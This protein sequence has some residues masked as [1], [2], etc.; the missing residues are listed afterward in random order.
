MPTD[1]QLEANRLNARSSTGPR[2]IIGKARVSSNALKH[3]LTGRDIVFPSENRNDYDAFRAGLIV[4]LDP[5]GDLE[6]LLAD[7]LVADAWRIRR[8]PILEAAL[9]RRGRHD[10]AVDHAQAI[11]RQ[12][13]SEE[14]SAMFSAMTGR[15][16]QPSPARVA[17]ERKL[18][19]ARI[20]NHNLLKR[21]PL[22]DATRV[23]ETSVDAFSNL[24]RH[25]RALTRSMYS[26]LHELQR[27]QAVRAG[28]HVPA[29]AV[30]DVNLD[31]TP[32]HAPNLQ[33]NLEGAL[34]SDLERDLQGDPARDLEGD[35]QGG[36]EGDLE[37]PRQGD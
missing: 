2:T 36:L 1:R 4:S 26:T 22:L 28:E 23:L 24:W 8:I 31:V 6:G 7:K 10:L 25:E 16:S 14:T 13:L 19:H 12:S 3:G 15:F 9:H 21:D 32:A 37:G 5:R 29:P 18:Q 27:L 35:I 17:A 34:Q 11:V 30:M 33:S 20:K